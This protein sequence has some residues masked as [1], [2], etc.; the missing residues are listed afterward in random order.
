MDNLPSLMLTV[1]SAEELIQGLDEARRRAAAEKS[2]LVSVALQD[3]NALV[4]SFSFK[5]VTAK[6]LKTKLMFEAVSLLSVPASEIELDY[7]IF[8]EEGGCTSGLFV[9]MAKRPLNEYL[10]AIQKSKGIPFKITSHIL[11]RMDSFLAHYPHSAERLCFIDFCE[12]PVAHLAMF[13]Q[14][15]CELLREVHCE[16][17]DDVVNEVIQSLRSVCGKSAEKKIGHICCAGKLDDKTELITKMEDYFKLKVERLSPAEAAASLSEPERFFHLNLLK[18]QVLSPK[19][20]DGIL[21][22]LNTAVIAAAV[23]CLLLSLQLV[24]V[25]IQSGKV[26]GS[27]NQKDYERALQ[28][29]QQFKSLGL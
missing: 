18:E 12:G 26:R 14:N 21:K 27:Y 13:F 10:R 2:Y 23:I 28:L 17:I 25:I 16:H 1:S 9:C 8:H 6:D 5:D 3:A 15:K 24:N 22:G 29:Q 7:Q 20:R 19:E 11:V 4:H